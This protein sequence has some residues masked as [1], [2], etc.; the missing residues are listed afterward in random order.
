MQYFPLEYYDWILILWHSWYHF[1][2]IDSK[3]VVAIILWQILTKVSLIHWSLCII[4]QKISLFYKHK[5]KRRWSIQLNIYCSDTEGT[6]LHIFYI[7]KLSIISIWIE[8]IEVPFFLKGNYRFC[9][10]IIMLFLLIINIIIPFI[11]L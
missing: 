9:D 4:K 10:R 5:Y 7:I 1:S 6:S 3:R 8:S 2:N 11:Y